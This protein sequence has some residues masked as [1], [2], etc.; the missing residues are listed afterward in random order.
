[1]LQLNNKR[2]SYIE[3][4]SSRTVRFDTDL[5]RSSTMNTAVELFILNI[6]LL[7]RNRKLYI[8]L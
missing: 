4:E 8:I 7:K 6:L 3:I 5:E 2:K 1:M